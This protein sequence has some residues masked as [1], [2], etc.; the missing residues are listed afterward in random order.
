MN[1]IFGRVCSI[2]LAVIILF[3]M[4]LVYMNERAKTASQLYLLTTATHFVD[5]VCNTGRISGQMMEQLTES[6]SRKSA[7][8]DI[9]LVHEQPEYVYN[10]EADAYERCL[11]YHDEEDIWDVVE[12]GQD[13]LFSRG[14]F[15]VI[16]LRQKSGFALLPMMD[17]TVSIRYG[18]TVKY[19]A[20]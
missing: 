6:L 13:Y 14:D 9:S 2:F 19:E 7:V 20:Y 15:L 16:T 1:D 12:Q 17:P 5:S 18:G 4:P 3:G 11:T 8:V 10:E